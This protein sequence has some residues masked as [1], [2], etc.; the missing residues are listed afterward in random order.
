MMPRKKRI[1][2]AIAIPVIIVIIIITTGILLYLNTDMFK[3]NKTLFLK[4]LGENSENLKAIQDVFESSEYEKKL[5]DNKYTETTEIKANYTN[6]LQTTSEDTSNSIN[7]AKIII[8]GQKDQPNK[9]CYKDFKLIKEEDSTISEGNQ[10]NDEN[11]NSTNN[12][13][14]IAEIE[15]IKNNDNYGVRFSDLFKQYL[16]VE[17]NN[18]K[19][20]FEKIG[21]SEQQLDNIPNSFEIDKMTLEDIKFTE[22]ELNN[23]KE[24]YVNIVSKNVTDKNFEK[25]SKQII[26]IND[27]NISTNAYILNITNE[28]LNNLYINL[29]EDLKQD[30][31]ILN[32]I[33]KIQEKISLIKINSSESLNLKEKFIENIDSTIEK[34]NKTNIGSQ[35][36]K[37]I[38]YENEGKTIRMTVQ[39]KDYEI[40]FDFLQEQEENEFVITIKKE[41]IETQ[42]LEINKNNEGLKI[43]IQNN[44]TD[45]PIKISFEQNK[46]E[47]NTNSSNDSSIKYEIKNSKIEVN[48]KQ[49][50]NIVDN[51]ENQNV[52]NDQNSIELNKLEKEQLNAVLNQVTNAL[53]QKTDSISQEIKGE[54]IQELLKTLGIIKNEQKI[55]GGEITETEKNRF[56]SKF[57]IL[58]GEDLDNENVL[59]VVEGL[60]ENVLKAQ[61]GSNQEIKVEVNKDSNNEEVG[62]TLEEYIKEKEDTKYNVTI[63]HD[64]NTGLVKYVIMT[65]VEKN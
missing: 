11:S 20:L 43:Y 38:V 45:N 5:Q 9:Y 51:F 12:E 50:T 54:D 42:K 57:E 23:I 15:Y 32:K 55:E 46:N 10:N 21:Y 52:L 30:D 59:K 62:R 17:N 26:S 31:I 47:T 27:K 33:E 24:R 48:I 19:E 60:K 18:L 8:K 53:Q 4:Y 65:P 35:E 34:I 13:Q 37:I 14:G 58:A 49:K 1:A 64:E 44:D 28:Q 63:E 22:E 41:D 16:L 40:N 56:N 29:L 61:V 3:S 6:N 2:L 7:K 39:G 25:K 36:T